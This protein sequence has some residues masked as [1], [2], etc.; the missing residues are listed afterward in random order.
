MPHAED[1]GL[2]STIFFVLQFEHVLREPIAESGEY[3]GKVLSRKEAAVWLSR[4]EKQLTVCAVSKGRRRIDEQSGYEGDAEQ[5][6]RGDLLSKRN[7]ANLLHARTDSF[8]DPLSRALRDPLYSLFEFGDCD[9]HQH[10]HGIGTVR[11]SK[12]YSSWRSVVIS[13]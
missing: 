4:A 8:R 1:T 6:N 5:Y 11:H 10:Q 13:A 12:V 3:I 7:E 2:Y 9:L